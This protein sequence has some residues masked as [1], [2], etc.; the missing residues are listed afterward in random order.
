MRN[1]V[2]F[3]NHPSKICIYLSREDMFRSGCTGMRSIPGEHERLRSRSIRGR[4]ILDEI[5]NLSR[6]K[7]ISFKV[8]GNKAGV[9]LL[10]EKEDRSSVEEWVEELRT[11]LTD[12]LFDDEVGFECTIP[13]KNKKIIVKGDFHK[14]FL[15]RIGKVVLPDEDLSIESSFFDQKEYMKR[16]IARILSL[17]GVNTI[18]GMDIST[19]MLEITPFFYKERNSN[20]LKDRLKN[21]LEGEGMLVDEIIQ[22]DF[23]KYED[24]PRDIFW[25]TE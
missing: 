7:D 15:R 22:Q 9:C 5:L 12:R 3:F 10:F 14:F 17:Q 1:I 18:M 25:G 19:I 23:G 8:V 16:F 21:F 6:M 13:P 4:I 20:E 11:R 24:P 2:I